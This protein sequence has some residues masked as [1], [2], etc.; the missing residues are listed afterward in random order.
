MKPDQAVKVTG[1]AASTAGTM[2]HKVDMIANHMPYRG[3][4]TDNDNYINSDNYINNEIY[5]NDDFYINN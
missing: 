1:C 5:I 2:L 3:C 4:G